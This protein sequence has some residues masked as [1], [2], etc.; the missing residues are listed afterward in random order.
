MRKSQ[1]GG[2]EPVENM[3]SAEILESLKS[4]RST[5][6]KSE[7]ALARMAEKG[8]RTSLIEKRLSALY[9]ALAM[10]ESIG[11][12]RPHQYSQAEL[13]EARDVL[14]G[15]LPSIEAI[16]VKPK[17]G[18]PQRTLMARRIRAL[19]LAIQAIDDLL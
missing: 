11:E 1:D 2:Q 3:A 13:S 9:V 5:I 6:Q 16:Y 19:E 4:I 17:T 12:Q 8:A 18:S 14:S 7:K 15:L 10:L